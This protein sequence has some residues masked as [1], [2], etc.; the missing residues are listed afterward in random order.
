MFLEL[1]V[2]EMQRLKIKS[3]QKIHTLRKTGEVL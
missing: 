2:E 1:T 3:D